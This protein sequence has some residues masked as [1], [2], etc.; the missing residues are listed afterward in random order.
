MKAVLEFDL[1]ESCIVCP[2]RYIETNTLRLFCGF[3]AVENLYK[4][5]PD[6]IVAFHREKQIS[7]YDGTRYSYCPLKIVEDSGFEAI[8]TAQQGGQQN[9]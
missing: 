4:K 7:D 3:G 1:P 6:E 8:Q 9:G 5:T 2:I